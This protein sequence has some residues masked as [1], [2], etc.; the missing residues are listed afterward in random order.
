M[1][2]HV[3]QH[4]LNEDYNTTSSLM[5]FACGKNDHMPE[6]KRRSVTGRGVH[7][8]HVDYVPHKDCPN[9]YLYTNKT[10]LGFTST[11]PCTNGLQPCLHCQPS[12]TVLFKYQM[13]NH[14]KEKHPGKQISET[15]GPADYERDL[16]KLKNWTTGSKVKFD[17]EIEVALKSEKF[18]EMWLE[19]IHKSKAKKTKSWVTNNKR[20]IQ[21]VLDIHLPLAKRLK[22]ESWYKDKKYKVIRETQD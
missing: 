13:E 1:V 17:D 3:S 11:D 16:V 9:Q 12:P 6:I 10:L 7:K 20:K 18:S 4:F 5:C 21:S 22:T 2:G 15:D 8:S 19:R 14:I